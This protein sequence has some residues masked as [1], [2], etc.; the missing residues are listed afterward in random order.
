MFNVNMGKIEKQKNWTVTNPG[1]N[2]PVTLLCNKICLQLISFTLL[3][4][5]SLLLLLI[6][7]R[8]KTVNSC[9]LETRK[10]QL[11]FCCY[12]IKHRALKLLPGHDKPTQNFVG[13]CCVLYKDW[14]SLASKL[15]RKWLWN[16]ETAPTYVTDTAAVSQAGPVPGWAAVAALCC[17]GEN[18]DWDSHWDS[19]WDSLPPSSLLPP[20]WSPW[21]R[22]C[23]ICMDYVGH[24]FISFLQHSI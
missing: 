8:D 19:D 7:R 14:T 23:V 16:F 21:W 10:L 6:L 17:Q 5:V 18:S 4:S 24:L 20:C 3:T 1:N 11:H 15:Y 9:T 22:H 13:S 2:S 12:T